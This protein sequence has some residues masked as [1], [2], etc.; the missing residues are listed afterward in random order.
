MGE[1]RDG[2]ESG[3]DGTMRDSGSDNGGM[4]TSE[5]QQTEDRTETQRE[6]LLRLMKESLEG[7]PMDPKYDFVRQTR[8]NRSEEWFRWKKYR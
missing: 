4:P 2:S 8:E 6:F 3:T 7:P 1:E 5:Q